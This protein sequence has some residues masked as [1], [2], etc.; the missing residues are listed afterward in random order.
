MSQFCRKSI[1]FAVLVIALAAP[2]SPTFAAGPSA[3][4]IADRA[5]SIGSGWNGT[6]VKEAVDLYFA[7]ADAFIGIDDFPSAAQSLRRG[8]RMQELLG[9]RID[10]LATAKRSVSLNDRLPPLDAIKNL[11]FYARLLSLTGHEA[12]ASASLA[13]V[14]SLLLRNDNTESRG[15]YLRGMAEMQEQ[16]GDYAGA[17]SNYEAAVA[18]FRHGAGERALANTLVALG[19]VRIATGRYLLGL[20]NADE[21]KQLLADSGEPRLLNKAIV[22]RGHL[23]NMLGRKQEALEEYLAAEKAYP[24]DIDRIER[25]RLLSGIGFLYHEM[26]EYELALARRKAALE[27][28]EKENFVPGIALGLSILV[29][30]SFK[31]GRTDDGFEYYRRSEAF[32]RS[33]NGSLS[34][35]AARKFVGDHYF[36]TEMFDLAIPF[37]KKALASFDEAKSLFSAASTND[38]LGCAYARLGDRKL[39]RKYFDRSLELNEQI[40]NRLGVNNTLFNLARLKFGEGDLQEALKFSQASIEGTERISA[41]VTNAKLRSSHFA[42][43]S[44]RFYFHVQLLME[45]AEKTGDASYAVRGLQAAESSRARTMLEK[46]TTLGSLDSIVA[47]ADPEALKAEKELLVSYNAASDR[48]ANLMDLRDSQEAIDVA[49]REIREVEQKIEQVRSATKQN[50]PLYTAIKDPQTLDAEELV[51]SVTKSDSVVLEYW[52]GTD[53]SYLWVIDKAGTRAFTLPDRKTIAQAVLDLREALAAHEPLQGEAVESFQARSFDATQRSRALSKNLSQM[54]LSPAADAI[55][56]K[57]IIVVPDG[58]LSS[59]P[60]AALPV[61]NSDFGEPLIASNEVIY[62]PSLQSL[63]LFEKEFSRPE[64][65]RRD[66]LVFSDPVFSTDDE[67]L[68]GIPDRQ[69]EQAGTFRLVESLR[70]LTRLRGSSRE[71][72]S[73]SAALGSSVDRLDGFSATRDAFIESASKGYRFVHIATHAQADRQR[74]DQSG[75]IFSRFDR[76]G[77]RIHEMV[78]LQDIYS[79]RLR[80]DLVVLSAC[81]TAVGKELKG[82]GLLSLNNAFL[83]TG[84]RAVLSTL[85][86]VEDGATQMLM[87]AFYEGIA[88][89]GLSKADSLRQAQLKL[90]QDPRF[91]S[92]F[93]W[94]AFTLHGASTNAVPTKTQFMSSRT[95]I[96][97]GAATSFLLLA[98]AVFIGFR[99]RRSFAK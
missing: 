86:K 41:S 75:I 51:R 18:A 3:K 79:M 91:S 57:R 80:C 33:N 27:I 89:R 74:P 82:E 63:L 99:R 88:K 25:G 76:N 43:V 42:S 21:A 32:S 95:L 20:A 55:P 17:E 98:L 36:H 47:D 65:Y 9:Q 60:F 31:A 23:L 5:Q 14:N 48:L 97:T 46:L 64:S 12:E 62:Q 96:A 19:G 22:T 38:M 58:E 44:D 34:L 72:D 69:T 70:S 35:G 81:E 83:Q 93:Y 13:Q 66:L 85:W 8:A 50:S 16:K 10:A 11:S 49:D 61:P 67:R 56:G 4:E 15:Y 6:A 92:P 40:H 71:A 77:G 1:A 90:R 94:A 53:K 28:F 73:I 54:L 7:A 78:R 37:Y 84:S 24:L 30:A 87:A 26:G 45:T 29:E 59:L 52:L 39:A 2:I 68:A